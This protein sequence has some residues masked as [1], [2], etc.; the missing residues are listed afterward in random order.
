M[1]NIIRADIFRLWRGKQ[2]LGVFALAALASAVLV[3]VSSVTGSGPGAANS[4]T[5]QLVLTGATSPDMLNSFI[6]LFLMITVPVF[7][8]VTGPIFTD[9]A[10][11]NEVAWGIS[12]TKLYVSRMIV[13]AVLCVLLLLTYKGV[14]MGMATIL[15]GFGYAPPGYWSN[16]LL[17]LTAQSFIMVAAC[18]FGILLVFTVKNPFVVVELYA[19]V[20]IFPAI[21][22]MILGGANIDISQIMYFDLTTNLVLFG[23]I[24]SMATRNI[25]LALATGAAWFIIP[26]I[27]GLAKFQRKEIK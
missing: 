23:D 10:V 25:L 2:I 18:M 27:I 7:T 4:D 6:W 5:P 19:G 26:T 3:V 1:M 17:S 15:E 20:I 12:R 16:L 9:G 21:V 24:G 22:A 14:G 11:K 13:C 8:I